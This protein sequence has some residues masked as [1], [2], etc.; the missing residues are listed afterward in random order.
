MSPSSCPAQQSPED[1]GDAPAQDL[2]FSLNR[3]KANVLED[4]SGI[5]G[6][7]VVFEPNPTYQN[8]FGRIEKRPSWA[9]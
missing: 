2:E 4:R 6:A 3:Y 7:P 9:R 5:E 1:Q 8:V